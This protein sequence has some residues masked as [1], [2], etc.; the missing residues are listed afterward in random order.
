ME[1]GILKGV[2]EIGSENHKKIN[3]YL[4]ICPNLRSQIYVYKRS[5]ENFNQKDLT[6]RILY[7]LIQFLRN[8]PCMILGSYAVTS[9]GFLFWGFLVGKQGIVFQ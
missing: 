9:L 6:L 4:W 2:L 8:V 3:L 1:R 5:D 7:P